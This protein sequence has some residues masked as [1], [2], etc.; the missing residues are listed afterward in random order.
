MFLETINNQHKSLESLQTFLLPFNPSIIHHP[1]ID[2]F[3]LSR[4][5]LLETKMHHIFVSVLSYGSLTYKHPATMGCGT[6]AIHNHPTIM[7][8][9]VKEMN[10]HATHTHPTTMGWADLGTHSLLPPNPPHPLW[11]TPTHPRTETQ[12]PPP[13]DHRNRIKMQDNNNMM[14]IDSEVQGFNLTN[15]LSETRILINKDSTQNPYA[16][17]NILVNL[18]QKLIPG[19]PVDYASS[20]RNNFTTLVDP[21]IPKGPLRALQ[22]LLEHPLIAEFLSI[23]EDAV[24][25]TKI[26]VPYLVVPILNTPAYKNW[27]MA[28]LSHTVMSRGD[29]ILRLLPASSGHYGLCRPREAA[30]ELIN[31]QS[32]YIKIPNYWFVKGGS[33]LDKIDQVYII[34]RRHPDF[35]PSV[36]ASIVKKDTSKGAPYDPFVHIRFTAYGPNKETIKGLIKEIMMVWTSLL[37]PLARN[38]DIKQPGKKTI[39]GK[40]IRPAFINGKLTDM[41]LQCHFNHPQTTQQQ[42]SDPYNQP[43]AP[44]ARHLQGGFGPRSGGDNLFSEIAKCSCIGPMVLHCFEQDKCAFTHCT[45]TLVD[46]KGHF[47]S[48]DRQLIIDAATDLMRQQDII[49]VVRLGAGGL[50]GTTNNPP[51][52]PTLTVHLLEMDG[53]PCPPKKAKDA[54]DSLISL[55]HTQHGTRMAVLN[56]LLQLGKTANRSIC[57]IAPGQM[58]VTS[59]CDWHLIVGDHHEGNCSKK[60]QHGLYIDGK[61][62]CPNSSTTC[63]CHSGTGNL[64][65]PFP[66]HLRMVFSGELS[67][68]QDTIYVPNVP[69]GDT[70]NEGQMIH[71]GPITCATDRPLLNPHTVPPPALTLIVAPIAPVPKWPANHTMPP[72]NLARG[73][74]VSLYG[75]REESLHSWNNISDLKAYINGWGP[76]T[77]IRDDQMSLLPPYATRPQSGLSPDSWTLLDDH[78]LEGVLLMH[79]EQACRLAA[80]RGTAGIDFTMD[81]HDTILSPS[82]CPLAFWNCLVDDPTECKTAL[83]RH[84]TNPHCPQ[85]EPL[86]VYDPNSLLTL[87]FSLMIH[88]ISILAIII[89]APSPDKSGKPMAPWTAQP[90]HLGSY[91]APFVVCLSILSRLSPG[92]KPETTETNLITIKGSA[93]TSIAVPNNTDMGTAVSPLDNILKALN[94][95]SNPLPPHTPITPYYPRTSSQDKTPNGRRRRRSC[96]TT[97]SLPATNNACHPTRRRLK[98]RMLRLPWQR[99]RTMLTTQRG[100]WALAEPRVVHSPPPSGPMAPRK[101]TGPPQDTAKLPKQQNPQPTPN[102]RSAA[103][104]PKV[105]A[106]PQR[107]VG[108]T[109]GPSW[110]DWP[111]SRT[112]TKP[113]IPPNLQRM[114]GPLSPTLHSPLWASF[115]TPFLPTSSP[116]PQ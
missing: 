93:I 104:L 33:P 84:L 38:P 8:W 96:S 37:Q 107:G 102:P 28:Y 114:R 9:C 43:T 59:F 89:T 115:S 109:T 70:D 20:P 35:P 31:A 74:P 62:I 53:S 66:H 19:T 5:S 51:K 78:L 27:L 99:R 72:V 67:G 14:D 52:A 68:H 40:V 108:T 32:C 64:R 46:T 45:M 90:V 81:I 112:G 4:I 105:S 41:D 73:R 25:R 36:Q 47:R 26:L 39:T 30:W 16:A 24:D 76:T 71:Q 10:S 56:W 44:F 82:H 101:T 69:R 98:K 111:N 54:F 1:S 77:I 55:S 113:L 3:V 86:E 106:M 63:Q 85:Q 12:T 87:V 11:N 83:L 100:D 17:N 23:G 48:A 6:K 57:I 50:H 75:A 15:I 2:M 22:D 103:A 58:G 80:L 95:V 21:K 94:R 97:W 65:C 61:T 49:I 7:G 79:P 92:G 13:T 29:A 60:S 18:V 88:G 34:L 91:D 42:A 110:K 116:P